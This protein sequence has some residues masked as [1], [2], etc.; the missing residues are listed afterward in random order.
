MQ[1]NRPPVADAF[2]VAPDDCLRCLQRA[3]NV[4]L[5]ALEFSRARALG[6]AAARHSD[7]SLISLV[8]AWRSERS[9]VVFADAV[10]L[11]F[12]PH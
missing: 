9:L 12:T 10:S 3:M 2:R 5:D 6:L 4:D 11:A 1:D 8:A 7:Y